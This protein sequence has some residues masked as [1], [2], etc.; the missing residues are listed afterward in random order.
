MQNTPGARFARRLREERERVGLSQTGLAEQLSERL[1]DAIYHS[2]V[3]RMESGQRSVKIDEAVAV[4]DV[5]RLPLA[6]LLEDVDTVG[7]R[8]DELRDEV[9]QAREAVVGYEEQLRLARGSV[10]AIER[11]IAEL[12]ASR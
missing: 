12:E 8:L 3:A 10:V 9:I 6:T 4:A 11:A 2:A 5:L 7:N 1:G